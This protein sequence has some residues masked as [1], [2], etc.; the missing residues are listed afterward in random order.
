MTSPMTP[1]PPI[2]PGRPGGT[3]PGRKLGPIADS[4][5]GAHRAWLEP[6]RE[7]HLASG[8]TLGDLSVSVR[9]AKSKLSEL[10]RGTGLYPRWEI[11]L[12]LAAEFGLPDCP[13]YRL[14]RR[15]ALD[16]HKSRDWVERS[17]EKASLTTSHT[18]PPMDH[19]AFRQLV[20][21][22]YLRYAQCFLDDQICESTVADCFDVL[23]LC[24]NDALASPDT[25]RFCWQVVR[26]TV[27][28][29]TPHLNGRPELAVAAFDTVALWEAGTQEAGECQFDESV[30]LF[31]TISRLP[32]QQQDVVVL[33]HLCGLSPRQTSALLG[34]SPAAV[35]S[36]ERHARRFLEIHCPPTIEG[37][38]S[39]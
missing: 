17:G 21:E 30:R 22:H 3:R 15:A 26:A 5:G 6:V 34:V 9:L 1:T 16:A 24:W 20:E 35:R 7:A 23:W 4:V 2:P 18:A 28:S 27:M 25:R 12:S 13:L 32:A 8:R 39:V 37:N 10:L 14:W 19:L 33:R 38:P 29:R 11:V 36:D 31:R